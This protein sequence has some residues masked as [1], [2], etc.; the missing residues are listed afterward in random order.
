M[1]S[2]GGSRSSASSSPAA[3]GGGGGGGRRKPSWRERENN[4]RRE[5][6]RRAVAANIYAGLRAQG[7]YNLPK[8]CDNN[9][10]LKALC[11]EAGWTVE[12]DGTT[13]RKGS[14]PPSIKTAGTSTNTTPCSSQRPSPPSSSFPSPY[15]SY[16]HSPSSS[17]FPSP[18][19]FDANMSS[20][21]FG[22]L[23]NSVPSSLPALRISNSAP[24]SPPLSS[25]TA[26]QLPKLNLNWESLAK[27][28]MSSLNVPFFAASAPASPSRC[29]RTAPATIPEC[30]ES[31]SST[32]DSGQWVSFQKYAPTMGPTSPTFNL[33]KPVAQPISLEDAISEKGKG[34]E[35][36]FESGAVKPWEG[37]RIHDGGIDDLELTLGS[38]NARI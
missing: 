11:A 14:K 37:E 16:Q 23:H 15:S 27:E 26:R 31:D 36:Q 12:P 19:H 18:S 30:N 21:P 1:M 28:S 7:N 2:E 6:R 32:I 38:G 20:Y 22:F 17:S 10:V 5:R 8:H 4:R 3:A 29:L 35:F 25:P 24:V 13:Y 34:I 33:V 9:E